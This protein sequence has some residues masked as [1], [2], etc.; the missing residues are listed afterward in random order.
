MSGEGQPDQTDTG[1]GRDTA[2]SGYPEEQPG[3][4]QPEGEGAKKSGDDTDAPK[5]DAGRDSD[6]GTA[7]G[8]PGAAG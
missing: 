3:G 2:S 5:K 1:G 8:N 6:P 7:T 4:A